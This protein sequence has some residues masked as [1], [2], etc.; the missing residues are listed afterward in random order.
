M[1][2]QNKS[3]FRAESSDIL[4]HPPSPLKIKRKEKTHESMAECLRLSE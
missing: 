4:T 1:K 3:L 2:E